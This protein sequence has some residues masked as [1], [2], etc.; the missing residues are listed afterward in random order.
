MEHNLLVVLDRLMRQIKTRDNL[1]ELQLA[2][3]DLLTHL[4]DLLFY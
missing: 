2:I 3:N 4:V 1:V